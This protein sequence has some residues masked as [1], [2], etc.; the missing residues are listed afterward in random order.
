M[1]MKKLLFVLLIAMSLTAHSQSSMGIW[2]NVVNT[3]DGTRLELRASKETGG[4]YNLQITCRY[5]N[6]S[7]GESTFFA[8]TIPS[9]KVETFKNELRQIQSKYNE[10]LRTAKANKV[11]EVEKDIPV[12]ITSVSDMYGGSMTY[13]EKKSIKAV[14][15]IYNSV[16]HCII[17]SAISGYNIYQQCEWLLTANDFPKILSEIDRTIQHQREYDS[18]KQKTRDLFQ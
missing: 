6:L 4:G 18:N 17:K 12:Q 15:L 8:L 9:P 16:P 13:P 1:S 2:G 11:Q 14:F 7:A 10:W 5:Y 3:E